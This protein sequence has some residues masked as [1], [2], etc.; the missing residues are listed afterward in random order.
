MQGVKEQ[1]QSIHVWMITLMRIGI[2]WHLLYEG[3]VKW[4]DPGWSSASYLSHSQWILAGF[5]RAIAENDRVLAIVD[6]LNIWGLILIGSALILGLFTRIAAVA[7]AILLFLYYMA[8]PSLIGSAFQSATSEGN[9]LV[10][11]KNL[12][13]AIALLVIATSAC[14]ERLGL[15]SL[16]T[17]LSTRDANHDKDDKVPISNRRL[18]LRSLTALPFIG[19]FLYA[20]SRARQAPVVDA[21]TSASTPVEPELDIIAEVKGDAFIGS[22]KGVKVSRL[23]LGNSTFGPWP[24]ARDLQFVTSLATGY[25]HEKRKLWTL[26]AAEKF[27]INTWNIYTSQLDLYEK[28][29]ERVRGELRI[30]VGVSVNEDNY[31][32]EIDRAVEHDAVLIYVQPFVSDRLV[33]WKLPGVISKAVEYIQSSGIPAGVGCHSL[34]VVLQSERMGIDPDFY[35]KTIHSDAYW[36]ATPREYRVEFEPAYW[37]CHQDHNR[38]HGNIFDLF[39]EKTTE[40]MRDIK[41]PWIGF[42]TLAGGALPVAEGLSYAFGHGAD[43]VSIGMF[44]FQLEESVKAALRVLD[45]NKNR[46]RPWRS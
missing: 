27:G 42:K 21:I 5:F 37:K 40:V 25:N 12:I 10:V 20:F 30:M 28:Y 1:G 38:Y 39:P 6:V 44:D 26:E 43:F 16:R 32:S 17:L 31:T 29:K 8:Y 3:L 35:V 7:G 15:G 23:I 24:R 45:N 4:F 34:E 14:R 36:S 13:E 2:G 41:K 11:N 46:P 18:V 33:D 19:G 9:Y 22:I